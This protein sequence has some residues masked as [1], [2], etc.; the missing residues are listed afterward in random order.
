MWQRFTKPDVLIY[1][2]VS[3]EVASERRSAEAEATWWDTL[4][5]RLQH[6]SQHADL[7]IET[8]NLTPTEVLNK[9]LAFL[10]RQA[11]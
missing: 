1:L 7:R 9:V 8:D 4:N 10:E 11:H 5:Q 3:Q 2:D 6:A